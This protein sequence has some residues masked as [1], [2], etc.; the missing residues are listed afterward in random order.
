MI[1]AHRA[2]PLSRVWG[3]GTKASSDGQHFFAGG[4]GEAVA[5]VNARHGNEPGVSFYTAAVRFDVEHLSQHWGELLRV[6]TSIRSGTV[7]ASAML[8]KLSAYAPAVFDRTFSVVLAIHPAMQRHAQM[9]EGRL[10]GWEAT[11][12]DNGLLVFNRNSRKG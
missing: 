10:D 8:R 7:T 5:D 11:R 2:L 3:D 1:D 4:P 12:R 9:P 6:A